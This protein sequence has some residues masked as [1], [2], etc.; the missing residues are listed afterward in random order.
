M[1]RKLSRMIALVMVVTSSTSIC[2]GGNL[3]P[4]QTFDGKRALRETKSLIALGQ[5]VSGTPGAKNAAS[6]IAQ[7]LKSFDLSPVVDSF[8]AETPRG[9]VEFQN[10]IAKIAG[11]NQRPILLCS[12]FDT[13]PG[14]PEGFQGANDSGSSSGTLLE[15][16]RVLSS[17]VREHPIWIV[18]FDGEE[19]RYSYS[20]RDGLHGSRHLAKELNRRGITDKIRAVIVLDMIGD[21]DFKATIPSNSD[22]QLIKMLFKAARKV[23]TREYFTRYGAILDDNIPF[24]KLGIA[25]LNIIDFNFGSA[26]G[27]NDY[28]HTAEDRLD[29]ISPESLQITADTLLEMLRMLEC[30]TRSQT[31][32]SG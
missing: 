15:L 11:K 25:T 28:W 14:M 8:R 1:K 16:A 10:V 24:K 3:S 4:Q 17:S 7:R 6:Q 32:G 20:K 2:L 29:K 26:P 13:K 9:E 5:R 23:G 31:I 19:C 27:K 30:Q 12:H 21:R 22:E 18:F